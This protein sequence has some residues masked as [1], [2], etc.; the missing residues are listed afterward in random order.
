M[1]PYDDYSD[2]FRSIMKLLVHLNLYLSEDLSVNSNT[3]LTFI[4]LITITAIGLSLGLSANKTP[5][6]L[7]T[8][9]QWSSQDYI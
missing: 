7:T 9:Y 6:Q 3:Q 2:Y 4:F 1:T 8:T 5:V